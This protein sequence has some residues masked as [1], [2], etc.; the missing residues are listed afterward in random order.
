M[1][2]EV[3][4]QA[5]QLFEQGHDK[6]EVARELGISYD[7]LRKAIDQGRVETPTTS[8]ADTQNEDQQDAQRDAQE[9]ATWSVSGTPATATTAHSTPSDK[10]TRSDEDRA[11]GEEMGVACTR[12]VERVLAAL[13]KL[14]GGAPMQ[15]ESC[16]DVSYGGALCALPALIENGLFRHL[17]STFPT[18][19]GY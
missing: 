18:L 1:T 13:G 16:R 15:F 19:T 14:P 11:A 6:T 9:E 5:Q 2:S 12:P 10:S 17:Q 8:A 4:R 7:T 3:I